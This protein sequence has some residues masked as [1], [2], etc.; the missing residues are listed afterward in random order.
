VVESTRK[1]WKGEKRFWGRAPAQNLSD[2]PEKKIVVK[3]DA[4]QKRK[5]KPAL[6]EPLG[7]RN[8]TPR[9]W[10]KEPGGLLVFKG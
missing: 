10:E 6:Q 5:S 2:A 3:P 8:D 9:E 4:D 7:N 1:K